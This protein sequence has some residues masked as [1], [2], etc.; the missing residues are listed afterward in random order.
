MRIVKGIFKATLLLVLLVAADAC[1]GGSKWKLEGNI[2]GLGNGSLRLVWQNES[3]TVSEAFVTATGDR[4]KAEGTCPGST[5]VAMYHGQTRLLTI[6]VAEGGDKIQIKGDLINPNGFKIRGN[7]L[8]ERWFAWKGE[9]SSQYQN[10]NRDGLNAEIE[11]YVKSH[12]DDEL[13]AVLALVDYYPSRAADTYR[14]LTSLDGKVLPP[15]LMSSLHSSQLQ[16]TDR[17][18]RMGI[19]TA[20]DTEGERVVLRPKD[21]R[22]TLLLLWN[23]AWLTGRESSIAKI[24]AL[25]DSLDDLRVYAI[26]MDADTQAWRP[27]IKG[28]EM[29]QWHHL[30]APAGLATPSMTSL[31]AGEL[32]AV[33]VADSTGKIIDIPALKNL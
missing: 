3:G 17:A 4:F 8:S 16:A 29:R 24:N 1:T 19:I 25:R 22:Y 20:W 32:P 27:S 14:L 30:W 33:I 18:G 31:G 11:K 15:S 28:D 10:P 13:S 2:R 26:Y 21:S 6:F 12:P 23:T 5:F 9:H 7:D